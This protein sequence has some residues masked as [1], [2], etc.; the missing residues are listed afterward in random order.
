MKPPRDGWDADEKKVLALLG[1]DVDELARRHANDPPLD[2][3]RAG[4]HD[5]LPPDLQSDVT[6]YLSRNAWNRALIEG[7][8]SAEL[9]LSRV[10]EDCLLARVQREAIQPNDRSVRWRWLAAALAGATLAVAVVAVWMSGDTG[11][12]SPAT[13]AEPPR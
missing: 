5:A 4:H 7:I 9:E 10:D 6:G 13:P 3:L 1:D 2:V 12:P 11:R 8:D